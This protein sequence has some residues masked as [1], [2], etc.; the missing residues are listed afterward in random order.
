VTLRCHTVSPRRREGFTL[1]ELLV[2]LALILVIMALSTGAYFRARVVME[3][4]A[5]T[6]TLQKLDS[7]L[8]RQMKAVIDNA[9]E[10]AREDVNRVPA[11]VRTLASVD[12]NHPDSRRAL[13]IWTKIQ[14]RREFPQNFW[15]V[16]VWQTAMSAN[17]G[18]TPKSSFT[19]PLQ[20]IIPLDPAT[21]TTQAQWD[22]LHF[23]SAA[24]LYIALT[25]ARRGEQGFNPTDH[26]GANAVGTIR[27]YDRDF[28]VFLDVWGMPIAFIRWPWA[29]ND[30][31]EINQPPYAVT[32][33]I[34]GLGQVRVDPQDPEMTLTKFFGFVDVAPVN[35]RTNFQNLIH[36]LDNYQ[37]PTVTANGQTDHIPPN[38]SPVIMSAGRNKVYGVDQNFKTL[39]PGSEDPSDNIYSYRVRGVGRK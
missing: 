11:W 12:Q 9:K 39:V 37:T 10:D 23:E 6:I 36:T 4:N 29:T 2:T 33:N 3:E 14:L 25:Q 20:G 38:L 28:K 19:K 32:N 27:L 22:Q 24:L 30:S 18:Q 15:E 13:V 35:A 26:L 21:A 17:T 5:T 7:Q 8:E 34:A 1:V 16:L 31:H